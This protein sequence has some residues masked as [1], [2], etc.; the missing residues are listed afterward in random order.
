MNLSGV[1][2]LPVLA[3]Y[4]ILRIL[5]REVKRYNGYTVLPLEH[6]TAS[7]SRTDLIGDVHVADSEGALFEGYEVKHNLPITPQLIQASFEKF[8][9]TPVDRFYILTTYDHGSYSEFAPDI[10]RVANEHGCQLIVNGVDQTLMYYLRLIKGTREFVHEYVSSIES[11]AT[12]GYQ[13]KAAW[14]EIAQT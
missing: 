1:S 6:H 11:D 14:N 12:V 2:R 9:T 3:V 8:R 13:L 4:S 10:Q 7:D 5:T